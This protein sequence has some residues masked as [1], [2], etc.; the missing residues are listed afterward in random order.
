MIRVFHLSDI[1][2][3]GLTRH[4]EH[5]TIFNA[6]MDDARKAKVDCFFI[7]GDIW[8]TKTLGISPE[9]IDLFSWWMTEMAAI[10]PVHMILGN[11]DLNLMNLSRQDAISPIINALNNPKIHLYKDSGVYQFHPGYNFCVYSL[12]DENDPNNPWDKVKPVPGEFNVACYH[13]SVRGA[14]LE[15]DIQLDDGIDVEFFGKQGYQCVM[16]GDIHK[17]QFLG[18]KDQGGKKVPWIGYPGSIIQGNYGEDPENWYFDWTL[19]AKSDHHTVTP[20][21]LPNPTPFITIPWL[22]SVGKTLKFMDKYT[23]G[24][25]FRIRSDYVIP[26]K[27]VTRLTGELKDKLHAAEV[28]FKIDDKI[29]RDVIDTG[30]MSVVKSDLRNVDILIK[31]MKDYYDNEEITSDHWETI[32]GLVRTY[33]RDAASDEDVIR[34]TKWSLKRL[35]FD[36]MYAYG[37]G[38]VINFEKLTGITGIFGPNRTGKSSVIA[39]LLY[40]LFNASDRGS[41]K[42]LH[43]INGRKDHCKATLSLD[44]GGVEHVFERQTVKVEK[45][46]GPIGVTQLNAW[47]IINGVKEDLNGEQRTDTDNIIRKLI[48]MKEDCLMTSISVQ[49]EMKKFIKEGAT[50]RKQLISRFF[51]LDVFDR[52]H[53]I[54]NEEVKE[55]K[56]ALKNLIVQEWLTLIEKNREEI[57]TLGPKYLGFYNE[58]DTK[59]ND[60]FQFERALTEMG[61]T[62][63]GSSVDLVALT[64]TLRTL[65][66]DHVIKTSELSDDKGKLKKLEEARNVHDLVKLKNKLEAQRK[67]ENAL[68]TIEH[69]YQKEADRLTTKERSVLKL[70]EVPCGDTF[71]MCKY[72]KDSHLDKQVIVDDRFNVAKLLVEVTEARAALSI[73]KTENI[74]ELIK[75]CEQADERCTS[76]KLSIS[77]KEV[78][79]GKLAL[80]IQVKRT[81]L[82]T[83]QNAPQNPKSKEVKSLKARIKT[84]TEEIGGLEQQARSV[85]EQKGR[86]ESE[87]EKFIHERQKHD[88]LSDKLRLF[89]LIANAFSKNGIPNRII[90]SQLPMI[91]QAM[92]KILNGIVNF[93]IE[94]EASQES[95]DLDIYINYGDSLR[96]LELGSGM[97]K[98][99]SSIALRVAL[100]E[101]SSLPKTDFFVIDEGFSDLDENSIMICNR[102]LVSLK[103]H[104]K[105]VIIITHLDGIKEVVDNLIE[106]TQVEHDSKVTYA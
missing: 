52:L 23:D 104:F 56:G 14:R 80:K 82:E 18:W 22:G 78:D 93:T 60:R 28:T 91:N 38:N 8:H 42:N 61:S 63:Q 86:L 87:I 100:H 57:V 96:L 25:R 74:E 65:E 21:S 46:K 79:L 83:V 49:D 3:R 11:H 19:D 15:T 43:L 31:M 77:R 37:E 58:I 10:A 101:M 53:K 51:D 30:T 26:Q 55:T 94:L 17:M 102:L 105:N 40:V 24:S 32:S 4:A 84:L 29:D 50:T 99:I 76:L 67:L 92:A 62:D 89:E 90:H 5:R 41:L 73:I 75:K 45:K 72:I 20:R 71:P 59:R 81:E 95:N 34:N 7:G 6:L 64:E 69:R 27:D 2:I 1:H 66:N 12:V 88:E 16:L 97:E 47:K 103:K 35:E 9:Y 48:G 106:I 85:S 13:G 36:N 98:V 44:I 70:A 54:V 39:T 33:V 68:Q